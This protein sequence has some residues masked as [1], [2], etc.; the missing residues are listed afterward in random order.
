MVGAKM[1]SEN[2]DAPLAYSE[3]WTFTTAEESAPEPT[4]VKPTPL[5]EPSP[6]SPEPIKIT[7]AQLSTEYDEI[8]LV[9]E[10]RYKHQLLEVSGT[11]DCFGTS[12]GAPYIDF[13]VASDA[14]GI[15][16]FLADDQESEAR[17]LSKGD[18]IT[19]IGECQG[20]GSYLRIILASCR[21]I[22]P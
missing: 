15:R 12:L 8:G 1:H 19:V 21:I 11:L 3:V 6:P 10:T 2:P 13:E 9:A 4:P 5:P 22:V 18:E 20:T 16:A 17:A 14:W 7:A